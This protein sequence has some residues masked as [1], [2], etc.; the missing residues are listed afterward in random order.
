M[1]IYTVQQK[2]FL[3]NIDSE[4][5]IIPP[6][7]FHEIGQPILDDIEWA[8]HIRPAYEWMNAQYS[9]RTGLP[10]D[11]NLIWAFNTPEGF[12]WAKD[13]YNAN[14]LIKLVFEVPMKNY[15]ENFLWSD[16]N[17]WHIHLNYCEGWETYTEI[18]DFN[19]KK[20]DKLIVPQGVTT[21]LNI[22][23]LKSSRAVI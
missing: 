7:P 2:D 15:K 19:I 9:M 5:F 22:S 11:R 8:E 14:D 6:K 21:R 3:K 18:F 1:K 4:G 23:W 17:G 20:H 16:Y 10:L 13:A 12:T